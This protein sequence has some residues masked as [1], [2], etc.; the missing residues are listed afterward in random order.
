MTTVGWPVWPR[1]HWLL[2][3]NE[4]FLTNGH[5]ESRADGLV[6]WEDQ[7]SSR[8]LAPGARYH[9]RSCS[10]AWVPPIAKRGTRSVSTVHCCVWLVVK[11]S[12]LVIKSVTGLPFT[13]NFLVFGN[14]LINA[15]LI[16]KCHPH[17]WNVGAFLVR[18][19][20]NLEGGFVL[21]VKYVFSA[22][23]GF[24]IST[25]MCGDLVA[26]SCEHLSYQ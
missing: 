13:R 11:H 10:E 12:H 19:S 15:L 20:E 21:Q 4:A 9:T 6:C 1:G 22:H 26:W 5:H 7:Q 2:R 25:S 3:C 16:S 8:G 24:I 23:V 14:T 17:P 18:E